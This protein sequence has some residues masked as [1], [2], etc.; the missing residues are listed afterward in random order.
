[1]NGTFEL[2]FGRRW[3]ELYQVEKQ[4][5]EELEAEFKQMRERLEGEMDLAY[6]DFQT[7]IM[8]EGAFA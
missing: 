7:Q 6:Q 8:R 1:M 2:E 5:R 4:R 3:K